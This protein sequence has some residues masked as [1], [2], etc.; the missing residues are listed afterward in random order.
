MIRNA[1]AVQFGGPDYI[2][3]PLYHGNTC[4]SQR[5]LP[6]LNWKYYVTTI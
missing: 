2:P 3:R 5:F 1:S 4:L 6:E